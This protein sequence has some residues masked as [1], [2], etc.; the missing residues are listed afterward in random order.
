MGVPAVTGA[1]ALEIDGEAGEVR[2]GGEVVLRRGELVAI[3]GSAGAVTGGTN[4]LAELAPYVHALWFHHQ[5]HPPGGPVRAH[6]VSGSELTVRALNQKVY[7]HKVG[8][9][10]SADVLVF[11]DAARPE[12]FVFVSTTAELIWEALTAATAGD[13]APFERLLDVL[14][15]PFVEAPDLQRYA[16]PAPAGCAPHVTFCGT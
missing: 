11:E 3:D 5:E 10:Q 13:R 8:T 6:V 2:I 14:G 4:N 16:S 12:R 15:H 1:G 9:E 7:F